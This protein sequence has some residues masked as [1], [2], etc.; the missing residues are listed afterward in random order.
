MGRVKPGMSVVATSGR[1]IGVVTEA[2]DKAFRLRLLGNSDGGMWLSEDAVF[3]YEDDKLTLICE[4]DGLH[5][6]IV[7]SE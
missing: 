4:E 1:R 3:T 2:R 6:Y 7:S 5:R